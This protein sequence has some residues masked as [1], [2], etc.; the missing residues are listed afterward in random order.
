MGLIVRLRK[1][2]TYN[3]FIVACNNEKLR[4]AVS[5]MT[6]HSKSF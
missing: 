5:K 6:L 3:Y 1:K 4:V 2:T